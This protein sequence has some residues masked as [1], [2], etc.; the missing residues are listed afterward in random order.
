[1]KTLLVQFTVCLGLMLFLALSC[2]NSNPTGNNTS[3]ELIII[4]SNGSITKSPDK[5]KYQSG[6]IVTLTAVANSG[7]SFLNWTGDASDTNATTTITMDGNKSVTANFIAGIYTL[8]TSAVNG[9]ITKKPDKAKYRSGEAVTLTAVANNGYFFLNWIGDASDTNA[10][11]TITMDGNKSV[12]AIFTDDI[13][14]LTTSAGNGSITRN[15][16]KT[17]YQS[18]EIV[19]LTTVANSGYTFLS[20]SGDA[21]GTATTTTVMMDGNKSVKASFTA[22]STDPLTDIDGN[23][24][25]TVRIGSQIWTAE[26]LRTTKYNDG[27]EIPLVTDNVEWAS[28]TTPGFCW[29]SNDTTN[30]NKFGALYNW[31]ALDSIKLAPTGWHIPTDAEWDTLQNYLISNGYNFDGTTTG[32]KIAK[33]MAARTDWTKSQN[34]LGAG[35]IGSDLTKNNSSGFSALPGGDR[36]SDGVFEYF[37]TIGTWWSATEINASS[38]WARSLS[39]VNSSFGISGGR[40]SFGFSVRLLHD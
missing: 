2:L 35:D 16:D 39:Y 34:P 5:A 24:Y 36:Y 4:A 23:V 21:S 17:R 40:K 27:T 13:Y 9:N 7:Y 25:R 28:L 8:T 10:T 14:T 33:S 22:E 3:Y 30:K 29:Y 26:N 38:A 31:Y 15:P 12:T 6:D 37:G 1:M 19:T 11:T 20:W 32:N 18:G